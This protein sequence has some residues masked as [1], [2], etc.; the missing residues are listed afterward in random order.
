MAPDEL[1]DDFLSELNRRQELAVQAAKVLAA[2]EALYAPAA[3]APDPAMPKLTPNAP[4]RQTSLLGGFAGG[5]PDR[6][7]TYPIWVA[8]AVIKHGALAL[9]LLAV[10][11]FGT[12][13]LVALGRAIDGPLGLPLAQAGALGV[14]GLA[15][16]G[17]AAGVWRSFVNQLKNCPW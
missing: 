1:Y 11:S 8:L 6:L 2:A 13:V 7:V 9:L 12:Q 15:G 5:K 16:I 4:G 17:T 3:L 10:L 14:G